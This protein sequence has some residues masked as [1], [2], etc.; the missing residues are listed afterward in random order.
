MIPTIVSSTEYTGRGRFN[1]AGSLDGFGSLG[2]T[3]KHAT[4]D[5][6]A[7]KRLIY[8]PKSATFFVVPLDV[9]PFS[10]SA[11]TSPKVYGSMNVFLPSELIHLWSCTI[12]RINIAVPTIFGVVSGSQIMCSHDL[13]DG[14]HEVTLT[15]TPRAIDGLTFW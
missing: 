8:L 1:D 7:R 14:T 10:L 5:E 4:W 15:S 12:D 2:P 3:Y 13:T 11:G 9:S 6:R